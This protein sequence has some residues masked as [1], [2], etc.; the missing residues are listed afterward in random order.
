VVDFHRKH[1]DVAGTVKA[2]EYDPNRNLP[3]AL[4]FY[5]NGAK[6]YMLKPELLKVGDVV[7]SSEKAEAKVGNSLPLKNIPVGFFVHN[8][9]L[10]PGQGGKFARSAGCS[11]QLVAKEGEKAILKMPS[12]E[13]RYVGLDNWATVGVL[14]NADYRNI[15]IGKA[16]RSRH[17][18]IR[19]TVR[20]TA[21]NPVDHPYGGGEQRQGRGLRRLKTRWGKP[22]GKGQKTR[23]PKKYSNI[24]IV[25]RRQVGKKKVKATQ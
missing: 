25:A 9:E 11:V 6:A 20:G 3:I 12:G 5:R 1:K 23:T 21:Q 2:F 7:L 24:F 8:V 14:S 13:L 15:N 16:G 4:V 17:M 18:G 10:F 19:P 22:A